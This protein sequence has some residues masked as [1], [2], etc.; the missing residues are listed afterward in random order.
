MISSLG[1]TL[2]NN[3]SLIAIFFVFYRK[4]LNDE[5]IDLQYSFSL[6]A[7]VFFVFLIVNN[8][9]FL[10]IN[11]FFQFLAILERMSTVFGLEEFKSDRLLTVDQ[12]NEVKISINDAD[13]TWGY[14]VK[15]NQLSSKK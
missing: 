3:L 13:Y 7:L 5:S 9:T 8:L 6:L 15:E 4:W 1:R 12:N 14:K 11:N 2:F 10:A